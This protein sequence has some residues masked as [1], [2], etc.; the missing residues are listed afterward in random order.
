M[1]KENIGLLAPELTGTHCVTLEKPM[2]LSGP[3][4]CAATNDDSGGGDGGRVFLSAYFLQALFS[5]LFKC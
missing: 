2:L 3:H 4:F 5:V 1:R